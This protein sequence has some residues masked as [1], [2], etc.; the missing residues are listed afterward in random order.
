MA[1]ISSSDPAN[2]MEGGLYLERGEG[3]DALPDKRDGEEALPSGC[4]TPGL[5]DS[6]PRLGRVSGSRQERAEV[7]GK[8]LSGRV[9]L[10]FAAAS[11]DARALTTDTRT[12]TYMYSFSLSRTHT[13]THTHPFAHTGDGLKLQLSRGA[14][15]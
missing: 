7:T 8:V 13:H 10:S 12:H 2:G 15:E 9:R 11:S 4:G 14:H 6:V 5:P 3:E 1:Q